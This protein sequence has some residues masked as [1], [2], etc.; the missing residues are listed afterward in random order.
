MKDPAPPGTV[1]GQRQRGAVA[2]IVGISIA[3]LI[4]FV[5][6]ALD[7][8]KLYIA[9]TELQNSSDACALAAAQELTGANTDQLTVAEAAGITTG[10]LNR[11]IFQS[12]PVVLNVDSSVTFSKEFDGPYLAKNAY[13]PTDALSMKYARCEVRRSEIVNWFIQVLNTLPG[14]AIGNQTVAAAAVATQGPAQTNCALPI[15]VCEEK[16]VAGTGAWIEGILAPQG[17]V[18]GSFRWVDFGN[19]GGGGR[20]VKDILSGTGICNLPAV[21]DLIDLK[22]GGTTGVKDAWNTRFGLYKGEYKGPA[23]GAPDSTGFTYTTLSW[24][25]KKEAFG[26]FPGQRGKHEPYQGDEATGLDI[27][28]TASSVATHEKGE[29]RRIEL[30]PVVNCATFD[31]DKQA[32]LK[33]WACML[34]LHPVGPQAGEGPQADIKLYLEYLGVPVDLSNPC[35]TAGVPGAIDGAGPKVPV[36][37]R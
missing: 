37:V 36:L 24:S 8:G 34:L 32:E 28:A 10:S 13:G 11:V 15:A 14:V 22:E 19:K 33:A 27:K 20:Q 23:D 16:L 29:S 35:V 7:L 17:Q 12:E 1:G 9:K 5:G 4:G 6:L 25:K 26:D 18:K 31:A 21:G 30:F 3:V 2:I